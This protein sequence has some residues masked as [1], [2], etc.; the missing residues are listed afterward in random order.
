MKFFDAHAHC[1]KNQAGGILLGMDGEPYFKGTLTNAQIET[2]VKD[3]KRFLPAYYISKNF[4]TNT[5]SNE[6]KELNFSY[7]P[8]G[9]LSGSHSHN[10]AHTHDT[11]TKGSHVHYVTAAGSVSS[12]FTGTASNTGNTGGSNGTTQA[13]DNMPPYIVQ[14]CWKR[15]S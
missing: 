15:V 12:S 10:F 1:I 11:D 13:H 3:D 9:T 8:T 6:T 4:V 2:I 5:S 7:Q 14:Y